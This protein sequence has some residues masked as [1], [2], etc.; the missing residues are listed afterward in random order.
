MLNFEDDEM[1]VAIFRVRT[2]IRQAGHTSGETSVETEAAMLPASRPRCSRFAS[3]ASTF[4]NTLRLGPLLLLGNGADGSYGI[5]RH[6]VAGTD[7]GGR[8]TG[9]GRTHRGLDRARQGGVQQ[10]DR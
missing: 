4:D 6:C 10:P 2:G 5:A 7:N 3:S 9:G 8:N 1:H